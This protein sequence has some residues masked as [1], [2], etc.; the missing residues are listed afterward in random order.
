MVNQFLALLEYGWELSHPILHDGQVS[1]TSIP[2]KG[3][4][5]TCLLPCLLS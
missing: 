2:E 5:F 1:V 4:A 3:S